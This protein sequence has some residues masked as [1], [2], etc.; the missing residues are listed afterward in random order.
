M[1]CSL[2]QGGAC[3]PARARGCAGAFWFAQHNLRRPPMVRSQIG[4]T[5]GSSPIVAEDRGT[6]RPSQ[7]C[8]WLIPE[9]RSP[10][11]LALSA[12]ERPRHSV[13]LL[14]LIDQSGSPRNLQQTP[15]SPPLIE[16]VPIW[17]V[18]LT[19]RA[20]LG[21]LHETIGGQPGRCAVHIREVPEEG[22]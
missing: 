7:A 4:V 13:D 9:P 1:T 18:H 11:V 16:P 21:M 17:G 3:S 20:T 5:C 12:S 14:G 15:S 6:L 19:R 10:I 2:A 8:C 22:K